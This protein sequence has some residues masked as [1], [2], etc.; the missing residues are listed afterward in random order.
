MRLYR[1]PK[2]GPVINGERHDCSGGAVAEVVRL[3]DAVD[4]GVVG[5]FVYRRQGVGVGGA[6][7]RVKG[8]EGGWWVGEVEG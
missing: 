3:F 6:R 5:C 4:E 2:G 1:F 7:V 8:E